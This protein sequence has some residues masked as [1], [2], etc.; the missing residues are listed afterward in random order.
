MVIESAVSAPPAN[1]NSAAEICYA[2]VS[3]HVPL[4]E[5]T[6]ERDGTY[7][8]KPQHYRLAVLQRG[9]SEEA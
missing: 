4:H 3:L 1:A 6:C 2:P 9:R 7:E 8:T 5:G